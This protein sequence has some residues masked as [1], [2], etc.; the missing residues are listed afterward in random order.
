MAALSSS[1][2][3]DTRD[4]LSRMTAL[5][6]PFRG[7]D[8]K[9]RLAPQAGVLRP[10]IA[11]AMLGDVLD[12][13]AAVGTTFLVTADRQAA[14][15]AAQASVET[16]EDPGGGHGRAVAAAL[17]HVATAPV[18]VL[19]AD[20]PCVRPGDVRALVRALPPGG[21]ALVEASDGTTNALA[22][23]RPDLFAPL[24]G[25]PSAQRFLAHAGDRTVARVTLDLA[26]LDDD[27]DTFEDI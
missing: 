2:A 18:A 24:Y 4:S 26:K 20:L 17:A 22:L 7:G 6:V 1:V 11:L 13:C 5:V 3:P 23:A 12:S 27:V 15:V 9:S 10:A 16:I 21:I 25:P 14:D 8:A 19:N